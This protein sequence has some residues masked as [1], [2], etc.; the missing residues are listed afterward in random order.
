MECRPAEA[1]V[2]DP[3]GPDDCGD[4]RDHEPGDAGLPSPDLVQSPHR[5]PHQTVDDEGAEVEDP[6][7][8]GGDA[9]QRRVAEVGGPAGLLYPDMTGVDLE[10][11]GGAL[12][13]PEHPHRARQQQG[14][15]PEEAE[16]DDR[17]ADRRRPGEDDVPHPGRHVLGAQT[18]AA[19]GDGDLVLI[20]GVL[21]VG[22]APGREAGLHQQPA[23]NGGDAL[24]HPQE[25]EL[26]Q[27]PAE[28]D[29]PLSGAGEDDQRDQMASVG[30]PEPPG[31]RRRDRPDDQSGEDGERRRPDGVDAEQHGAGEG[32]ERRRAPGEGVV[33]QEPPEA[34]PGS[35]HPSSPPS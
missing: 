13:L 17:S 30:R 6:E 33:A 27:R 25:L 29:H 24:L 4:G 28:H 21:E 8:L 34:A 9:V 5:V 32:V 2:D 3:L 26:L 20:G 35:P 12:P 22:D 1:C 7:L 18:S 14:R 31:D 23:P 19:P 11:E 10:P 16:Q 15:P